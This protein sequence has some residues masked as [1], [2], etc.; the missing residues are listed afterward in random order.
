MR[1]L[2]IRIDYAQ[3]K[4]ALAYRPEEEVELWVPIEDAQAMG[5]YEYREGIEEAPCSLLVSRRSWLRGRPGSTSP[6]SPRRWPTVLA[7]T[8]RNCRFVPFKDE[9]KT[10]DSVPGFKRL[11]VAA[12][13]SAVFQPP[14]T[15]TSTHAS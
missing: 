11:A 10:R 8:T 3:R 14:R 15:P 7:A 12:L 2:D 13:E 9:R 6:G 1:G 4:L 5:V